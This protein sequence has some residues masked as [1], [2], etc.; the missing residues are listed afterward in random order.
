MNRLGMHL[1]FY[2]S[3]QIKLLHNK[4]VESVLKELSVRVRLRLVFLS[5]LA[6]PGAT[7]VA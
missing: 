5:H 3:A 6:T 2:G 4:S 1:L 7:I